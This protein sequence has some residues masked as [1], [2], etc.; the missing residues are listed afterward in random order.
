MAGNELVAKGIR[1]R[2]AAALDDP[3]R[4]IS[5]VESIPRPPEELPTAVIHFAGGFN[6][7][8]GLYG[9]SVLGEFSTSGGI[10][11]LII[12]GADCNE[13]DLDNRS[14]FIVHPTKWTL[15]TNLKV[16][17]KKLWFSQYP[18]RNYNVETQI[19]FDWS[20]TLFGRC[21][22]SEHPVVV[23]FSGDRDA[24][25]D[26]WVRRVD[27]AYAENGHLLVRSAQEG[28]RSAPSLGAV[29]RAVRLKSCREIH[30]ETFDEPF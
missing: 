1:H 11:F 4:V 14:I 15:T 8:P 19:L 10:P 12:G 5:I 27:W 21:L 9:V 30:P 29:W 3:W 6:L 25:N 28:G 23:S 26:H 24:R 7:K 17:G 13:C 16:D 18:H 22:G 2:V 20:R